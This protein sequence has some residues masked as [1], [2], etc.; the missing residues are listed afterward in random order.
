[1]ALLPHLQNLQIEGNALKQIR[2]DIIKGGTSRILK[3][4]REKLDKTEIRDKTVTSTASVQIKQTFP[5][6]Y[7]MQAIKSL[8][9]AMKELR[10]VSDDVFEDAKRAEVQNVDLSKNKLTSVPQG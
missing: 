5:N 4:L 8:N 3:F 2:N 6:K 7:Q 1:M 9:L 10:I